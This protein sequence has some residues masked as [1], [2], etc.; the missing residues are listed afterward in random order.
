M[1]W[2][3]LFYWSSLDWVMLQVLPS[4][5]LPCSAGWFRSGR[6]TFS[7]QKGK[8]IFFFL[9]KEEAQKYI[10]KCHWN[11]TSQTL[12]KCFSEEKLSLL[13]QT[14]RSIRM[15]W[16]GL[17]GDT[18]DDTTWKAPGDPHEFQ[19]RTSWTQNSPAQSPGSVRTLGWPFPAV[20]PAG[21][22]VPG[23]RGQN[24]HSRAS[25]QL[26]WQWDGHWEFSKIKQNC[27]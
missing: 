9:T 12:M 22:A 23:R 27:V 1:K 18:A 4:A 8:S 11:R 24:S 25:R 3:F 13:H 2:I 16:R 17:D 26:G 14:C 7:C 19:G 15:Q 20:A 6:S 5:L 21:M 10:W